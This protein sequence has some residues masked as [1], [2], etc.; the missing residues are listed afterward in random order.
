M[1]SSV[2]VERSSEDLI[3]PRNDVL[4]VAKADYSDA[5]N[6]WSL[7]VATTTLHIQ[8]HPPCSK[9]ALNVIVQPAIS[10]KPQSQAHSRFDNK[11]KKRKGVVRDEAYW[12]RRRKN[13]DAAK[14]SRDS[15]RRKED[16][17]AVRA[18]ILEQENMRLRFEVDR[19]RTEV[20]RHRSLAAFTSTQT[21]EEIDVEKLPA[22]SPF[23]VNL[24]S[25]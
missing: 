19:L 25:I 16:E 18:A 15:R 4:R 1:R 3:L 14:R 8:T 10:P 17:V 22:P 23:E 11:H 7:Q 24:A 6:R 20:D 9:L 13:N 5:L 2:V 12:E 21:I